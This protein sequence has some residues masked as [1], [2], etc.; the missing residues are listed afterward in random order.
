MGFVHNFSYNFAKTVGR[1][2]LDLQV[3]GREH[4]IEDGPALICANHVSYL[5]PPLVG[6]SFDNPIH[7]LARKSLYSNAFARWLFPKLNVVPIDQDRAGFTGLKSIIRL[8]KDGKRVIIFPEGARSTDGNLQRGQPGTGLVVTKAKVPV[9]PMRI[10][11]AKEALPYGSGRFQTSTVTVVAGP[12]IRF[13]LES[14]PDSKE[15]YQV[16]SDR[17]MEAIAAISCPT[18]RIPAPRLSP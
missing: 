8:L 15:H 16:V 12:V 7:Y 11:G 13:D 18:D 2:A 5:D 6:T 3:S 17:I 9:L 10:F 4:L 1:A 14:L